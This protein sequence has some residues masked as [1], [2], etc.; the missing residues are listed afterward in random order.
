MAKQEAV[1]EPR[2]WLDLE[3][4]IAVSTP[5]GEVLV[6]PTSATHMY[7]THG[8]DMHVIVNG[9][10]VRFSLHLSLAPGGPQVEHLD[11]SR[12]EWTH[13]ADREASSAAK[14]K[15]IAVVV[16]I[17]V[18]W[19]QAS[20]QTIRAADAVNVNNEV[21]RREVKIAEHE[22]AIAQLRAEIDAFLA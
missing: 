17:V 10:K 3:R 12:A 6:T 4:D 8:R 16:P 13:Y 21:S 15:I 5:L 19:A 2:E 1:T 22:A 7:V 18:A 20:P 9:V 14:R 11:A